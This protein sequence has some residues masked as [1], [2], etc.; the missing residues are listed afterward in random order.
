MRPSEP[1]TD[2]QEIE[3][4]SQTIE[5]RPG[6]QR[7]ISL[8]LDP[9]IV[10]MLGAGLLVLAGFLPWLDR[11]LAVIFVGR[12]RAWGAGTDAH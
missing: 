5:E 11:G 2:D 7:T 8:R 12:D 6:I 4:S 9:R 3:L 1:S 10:A